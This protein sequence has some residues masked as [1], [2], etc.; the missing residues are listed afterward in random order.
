[1]SPLL[2][3]ALL[4]P[5][6]PGAAPPPLLDP[7]VLVKQLGSDRYEHRVA[8]ERA[9]LVLGIR[10]IPAVEAGSVSADL[11]VRRRCQRLLK[12][13]RVEL[14]ARRLQLLRAGRPDSSIPL[15]DHYRRMF[16]QGPEAT[17]LFADLYEKEG[18]LFE[19]VAVALRRRDHKEARRLYQDHVERLTRKSVETPAPRD[20]RREKGRRYGEL[21]PEDHPRIVAALLIGILPG[22]TLNDEGRSWL[23]LPLSYHVAFRRESARKDARG[24]LVRELL[25]RWCL[26]ARSEVALWNALWMVLAHGVTES[27]RELARRTLADSKSPQLLAGAACILGHHG[28]EEDIPRLLPLLKRTENYHK[29]LGGIQVADVALE[30]LVRLTGQELRDYG[31]ARS[32]PLFTISH[33]IKD[34]KGNFTVL[35]PCYPVA[36][37]PDSAQRQAAFRKWQE[38]AK[39]NPK[40]LGSS[41]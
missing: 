39:N 21:P 36:I 41:R 2:F 19:E 12:Q 7:A 37:Y 20:P 30:S 9:L 15:W 22:M 6:T 34:G 35:M 28:Q 40:R 24:E 8:A 32:N 26:T 14:C 31:T 33:Q 1:M 23:T 18:E 10:A 38:W 4:L 17:A 3:L 11:E 29:D 16:G 25:G 5:E 13:L 27:G